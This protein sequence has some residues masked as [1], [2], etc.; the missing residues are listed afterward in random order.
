MTRY[1]DEAQT[2]AEFVGS[3]DCNRVEDFSE[4]VSIFKPEPGAEAVTEGCFWVL[5]LAGAE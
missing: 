2:A 3:T 4:Y 5:G 1:E